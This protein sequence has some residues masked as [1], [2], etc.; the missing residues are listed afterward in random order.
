[1]I[2]LDRSMLIKTTYANAPVLREPHDGGDY[3]PVTYV[4]VNL[5]SPP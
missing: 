4:G 5:L 2:A 1:V 3:L